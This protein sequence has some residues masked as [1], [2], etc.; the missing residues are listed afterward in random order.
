[1]AEKLKPGRPKKHPTNKRSRAVLII[2]KPCE[3]KKIQEISSRLQDNDTVNSL[4]DYIIK[5]AMGVI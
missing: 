3:Y 4:N 5:A 2:M 1:M